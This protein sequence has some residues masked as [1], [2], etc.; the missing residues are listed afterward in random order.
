MTAL[1]VLG[2]I[3]MPESVSWN[4]TV[5]VAQGPTVVGADTLEVQAYDK[6][7]IP[8]LPG[9]VEVEVDIG[10]GGVGDPQILVIKASKY[11]DGAD[12]PDTKYVTYSAAS[13]ADP[14]YDLT[15]P[16]VLIGKG[17]T[18]L[19]SNNLTNLFFK[20]PLPEAVTI[21]ILVGRVAIQEQDSD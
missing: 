6:I 3:N 1:G 18:K 20:N 21:E 16:L 10:L 13:E 4:F 12:P 15:A 19:L 14:P 9:S 17:A 2:R 11:S 8:L 5:R 7:S